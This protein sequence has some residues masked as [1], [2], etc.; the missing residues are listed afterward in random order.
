MSIK[1]ADINKK[2]DAII[3]P[4]LLLEWTKMVLQWEQDKKK[5]NPYTHAEKGAI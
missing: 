5:T 3:P 1:H 4:D 2:F